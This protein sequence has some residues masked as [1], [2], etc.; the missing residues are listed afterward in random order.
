MINRCAKDLSARWPCPRYTFVDLSRVPHLLLLP[1][2]LSHFVREVEKCTVINPGRITR[3]QVRK[4]LSLTRRTSCTLWSF[5]VTGS[6]HFCSLEI[7]ERGERRPDLPGRSC[8][9]LDNGGIYT[10]DFF[11]VL[12]TC[13]YIHFQRNEIYLH[14]NITIT[15][16]FWRGVQ[17]NTIAGV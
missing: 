7:E 5:P 1:S 8:Q 6:R 15:I 10:W 3:G 17:H 13:T 11:C 16:A 9:D 12:S 14:K 2:D 4:K